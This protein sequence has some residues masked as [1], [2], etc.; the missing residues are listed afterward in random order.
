MSN[1]PKFAFAKLMRQMT[2]PSSPRTYTEAK[3]ISSNLSQNLSSNLSQNQPSKFGG[4]KKTT[5]YTD[6]KINEMLTH[7][8]EITKS[9]WLSIPIGTHIRYIKKDGKFQPGGFVRT[10]NT[11]EG[12]SYFI[13]ENDKFGS[14]ARNPEY[15]FWPMNFDNVNRVFAKEAPEPS[16]APTQNQ[17][18]LN[19]NTKSPM[20]SIAQSFNPQASVDVGFLQ[21]QIDDLEKKY[22]ALESLCKT[23]QE[24]IADLEIFSKNIGKYISNK[25]N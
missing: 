20:P 14:K 23:Q 19:A 1:S 21:K 13:L 8:K 15:T 17:P 10:K 11:K 25:T 3:Q 4:V 6:E 5:E 24:K 22:S 9:E 16:P 7:Y 18:I 2:P 12:K